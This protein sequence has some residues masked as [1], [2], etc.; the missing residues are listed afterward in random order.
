MTILIDYLK[1]IGWGAV[2]ILT[3]ALSLWIL[4]S[5]FA[6]LTPVDE[7]DELKKGN[8]AVALVMASV[9]LGF[10]LVISAAI[11]PPPVGP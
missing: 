3:M 5:V 10:A 2:G 1:L 6:W 7:W 9:I 11:A 4:L 8:L